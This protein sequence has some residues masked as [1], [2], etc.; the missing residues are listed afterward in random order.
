[1]NK[2]NWLYRIYCFFFH[3]WRTVSEDAVSRIYK[4]DDCGHVGQ[5]YR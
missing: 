3:S 1:M 5:I 2:H 4:C